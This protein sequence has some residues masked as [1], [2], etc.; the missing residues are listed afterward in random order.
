VHEDDVQV[1]DL[2]G[3]S[4]EKPGFPPQ[5]RRCL[6]AVGRKRVS[7]I[8]RWARMRVKRFNRNAILSAALMG[9]RSE[10][11]PTKFSGN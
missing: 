11:M 4:V 1:F 5:F 9:V 6:P 3:N 8:A 10:F 7:E 2:A